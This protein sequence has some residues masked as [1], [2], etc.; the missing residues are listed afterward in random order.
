M[1]DET[2]T[3]LTLLTTITDDDLFYVVD[4]PSGSPLSKAISRA[5]LLGSADINLLNNNVILGTGQLRFND[6]TETISVQGGDMI[7]DVPTGDFFSFDIVGAP[8]LTL[9]ATA[10]D[11]QGNQLILGA[12][13]NV[14]LFGTGESIGIEG[15]NMVLDV[16]TGDDFRFSIDGT[17]E[18]SFDST[19]LQMNSNNL[20]MGSGAIEFGTNESISVQTNDMIFDVTA[21]DTFSWDI[22]GNPE[23][24]LSAT[25]LTMATTAKNLIMIAS[26]AVGFHQMGEITDPASGTNSGKFYVK[27][28]GGI[29][30]PFYIGDGQTAIDLTAG[31]EVFTW[32]ADHSAGDFNLLAV[33]TPSSDAF[34]IITEIADVDDSGS[35]PMMIIN[36][37]TVTGAVASRVIFAVQENGTVQMEV[38]ANGDFNLEGNDI[39]WAGGGFGH[40]ILIG[41]STIDINAGDAADVISIQTGGIDRF[42]INGTTNIQVDLPMDMNSNNITELPGTFVSALSTVTGIAGDFVMISDTTDS[43]NLKKV[44]VN[45]LLGGSAHDILSATHSDAATATRVEGDVLFSDATQWNR[46]PRGT[47]NQALIATA[48]TVNWESLTL[49]THVSGAS[50]DLSDTGVIV[51]TDETNT[52]GA[53]DQIFPSTRLRIDTAGAGDVLIATSSEGADRTITI[54]VLGGAQTLVLLGLAQVFALKTFDLDANT[55]TGTTGEFDTALQSDTFVFASDNISALSASTVAQYNTSLTAETFAF[56]GVANA[57]GTLNQNISATG[58]WQEN[59]VNISPIGIHDIPINATGMYVTTNTPATGLT[60]TNFATNDIDLQTWDFTSTTADETVQFRTPFPR[61]YNNGAITVTINWSHASGTGNVIW[62]VGAVAAG[63][64]EAIDQAF[65]FSA[66]LTDG[67]GTN[68][69]IQSVTTASFTPAGTPADADEIAFEIQRQGTDTSDTFSGTARLHS[70]VIHMTTDTATAA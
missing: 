25:A 23:M 2:L 65:T 20:A 61:N 21:G 69:Q 63:N 39:V 45:D 7:F 56:I 11:L 31:G 68:D 48:S 30:K 24:T 28:V 37:K 62:R 57:W 35:A 49:A 47:D 34:S 53:F 38:R 66:D 36:S 29:S 40:G 16:T 54:P 55:L 22:A 26:G 46:L 59:T 12:T 41:T 60:L 51:R 43:G 50:T 9:S 44:D 27:D 52:F 64:A 1:P 70:I 19:Q 18:Y 5:N 67:N 17:P 10:L 15:N 6:S 58:K 42:Q 3:A 13:A 14:I 4:D 8:Q 33:P 32:T